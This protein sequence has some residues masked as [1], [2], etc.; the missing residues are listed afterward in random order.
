M[1]E[2]KFREWLPEKKEMLPAPHKGILT[3]GR[4]YLQYTGLK[5]IDGVE[6]YDQKGRLCLRQ[7][8][9]NSVR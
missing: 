7:S 4:T 9:E 3:K 8:G 1:I 5:D 6:I 2:L